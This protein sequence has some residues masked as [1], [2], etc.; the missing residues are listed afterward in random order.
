MISL[1]E[2]K[3]SLFLVWSILSII[4]LFILIAPLF[5]SQDSILKL[6]PYCVS[7]TKYNKECP[8]CGM[9]RAFIAI[10]KGNLGVAYS[11]NKAAIP[12]YLT[13]ALNEV[14]FLGLIFTTCIKKSESARNSKL[15]VPERPTYKWERG[16]ICRH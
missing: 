14:F 9:S 8:L 3:I 13:F 4:I 15:I 16:I 5:L 7:R 6:A 1:T 12:T 2:L 10:S 11:A